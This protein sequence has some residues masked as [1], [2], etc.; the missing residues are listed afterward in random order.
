M[1]ADD[2][3]QKILDKIK[4][5]VGEFY[6][7]VTFDTHLVRD[8]SGDL[9]ELQSFLDHFA[10]ECGI[11][12]PVVPDMN[13]YMSKLW[14]ARGFHISDVHRYFTKRPEID[15]R[16]L[17]VRR[18]CEIVQAGEWPRDMVFPRGSLKA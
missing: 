16:D 9:E 1:R 17:T 10:K 15:V 12:D 5:S 14:K 11:A 8:Y 7:K 13:S 6:P 2:A 3:Q 4:Q 18:L